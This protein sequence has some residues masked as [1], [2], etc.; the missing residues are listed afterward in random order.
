LRTLVLAALLAMPRPELAAQLRD[1]S[2][3]VPTND[4]PNPYRRVEPWGDLPMGAYAERAS[5]IG[6][7]E[8]PDGNL[9]VLHRCLANSCASRPESPVVKLDPA[10]RLLASWGSGMMDFPHGLA[11]DRDGN[12]WAADQRTHQ[13]YKWDSNGRLLMTIG[14][15]GVAGDPPARLS[16]PTD[17]EI[18][19]NGDI[20]VTEGHSFT[21][22]ANRVSKFARDGSFLMS[23]G[24]TGSG[25]GQF[26]VPHAV[27]LDSRGRVFIAD[28]AN[29]RIQ[30]FDQEGT[31]LEVWYQFGRP[32]GIAIDAD[33][34][35]YVADSESWGTDNPG[36]K[37]GIRV[38]SA[39]DG[40]VEYLIEDLEPTAIEHSG[41]EGLGVDSR[42]NVYGAVVRRRMLERHELRGGAVASA[43]A[44]ASS[45]VRLHVGHV[46]TAFDEAPAG[47][48]MLA[49]ATTDA[50]VALL[51]ANF[52]AGDLSD[53]E[54]MRRHAA[55]VLHALDPGDG[56]DGR[57]TGFGLTRATVAVAT[58]A[59]LAAA[60]PGASSSVRTHV[61]HIEQIART[62][63]GRSGR[64]ASVARRLAEATSIREA[65][66]L[67][68]ELRLLTYQ[69]VEGGD[70][71]EDGELALE[72]EAGLQQLEAHVYLLLEA[73]GL[74]R[75]IR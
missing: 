37:K 20:F 32:S 1:Q 63:V 10:G 51:H 48:G 66:P 31:F 65:S 27:A 36:W 40:A 74:P 8:G 13:I 49:S 50:G 28:R 55:H 47:R 57:G 64:A 39:R 68:A 29:N 45:P 67:V 15:R 60:S 2:Q 42:G 3:V 73:E 46:A 24:E 26:N 53:L 30:V 23:W 21:R 61:G 43:P 18:A 17:V 7:E 62:V 75:V 72:G 6:A 71:D 11:V 14:E 35:I 58:H 38:G 9:Y 44:A 69:I 56:T 16:E 25:P 5:F 34:R 22:G 54:A 70:V 41:A 19:P 59:G 12:V 4:L 33:D 52:A